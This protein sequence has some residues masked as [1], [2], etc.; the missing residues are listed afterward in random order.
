[1]YD[2]VVQKI[3]K[4][5]SIPYNIFWGLVIACFFA[6]FVFFIPRAISSLI[7]ILQNPHI[8]DYWGG[9]GW[10]ITY[11]V[12]LLVLPL[13][14]QYAIAC[15]IDKEENVPYPRTI[16]CLL[17]CF[18]YE[19]KG[20][21]IQFLSIWMIGTFLHL[22]AMSLPFV[23]LAIAASPPGNLSFI[24][25][26]AFSFLAVCC[27]T[28]LLVTID[29]MFHWD[30]K[31]RTTSK[32]TFYLAIYYVACFCIAVVAGILMLVLCSMTTLDKVQTK[33]GVTNMLTFLI[34]PL[35][36][37]SL[38]WLTRLML[39]RIREGLDNETNNIDSIASTI[40]NNAQSL[41]SL[42]NNQSS[43]ELHNFDE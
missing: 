26:I 11:N 32:E 10:I 21:L 33:P 36:L 8:M 13:S 14:I 4:K 23:V 28:A 40:N 5:L 39:Q 12:M 29:R 16:E 1:M 19:T 37:A 35:L 31:T 22:I 20:I 17:C 3:K 27:L 38:G 42:S 30:R 2:Y 34:A 43:A 41:T 6:N 24:S 9:N 15:S 7:F 18:S 25:F